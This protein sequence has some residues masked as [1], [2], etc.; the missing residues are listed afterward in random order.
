[1]SS[2]RSIDLRFIAE[3]VEFIRGRGYVLDFS[4][5]SFSIFFETELDIDIDDKLYAAN[6]GSKGKRLQTF[7]ARVD[8]QTAARALQALWSHR[9]AYLTARE[10][11]DPVPNA[12]GRLLTLLQGLTGNP[13]SGEAPRPAHDRNKLQALRKDLFDLRS[14]TPQPRGFAFETYLTR[15]FAEFCLEPRKSFRNTGEQIDG[16]F[17]LDQEIYLLEAK[18]TEAPVG[19][20][21]MRAFHGKLDKAAWTRGLFISYNGFSDVGLA[22]F[23]QARQMVCVNGQDIYDGLGREIPLT[24]ILRAKVRHAAE[25]GEP[26]AP[27]AQLFR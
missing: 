26:F 14:M 25:T 19:V 5:S 21:E 27:L 20:A 8:D 23:G 16:S 7:L 11:D 18:W 2:L 13:D 1:M 4:D 12:E 24:D 6:G 22:A 10:Q 17:L 3:L 9:A 15:L